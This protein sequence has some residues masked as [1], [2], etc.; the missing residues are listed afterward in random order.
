MRVKDQCGACKKPCRTIEIND[1]MNP[2][3]RTY[4]EPTVK[5]RTNLMGAV[6]FQTTQREHVTSRLIAQGKELQGKHRELERKFAE[7]KAEQAEAAVEDRKI[8]IIFNKI[9]EESDRLE[10]GLLIFVD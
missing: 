5:M 6:Q 4:F 8:S 7:M 2:S 3:Y 1:K 10:G 9:R